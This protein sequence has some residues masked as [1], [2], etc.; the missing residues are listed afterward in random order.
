MRV[1]S[2]LFALL[3]AGPMVG[4]RPADDGDGAPPTQTASATDAGGAGSTPATALGPTPAGNGPRVV[5][6]GTSLTAGYGLPSPDES[7]VA[8]LQEMAD[9]AGVPARLVNAGVS[10][11]TSAG[12]LRRIG[13]VVRDTVDVLVLELGANDGLRG[14]DTEALATNL[15]AIVDSTRAHWPAAE[16]V[17]VGMRA[18]PN[19]GAAYT[20]AFDAVF[21][22][23]ARQKSATLVPFLLDGVAGVRELNQDDGIHPTVEG[24]RRLARNVWP[25]LLPALRRS[26][27]RHK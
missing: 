23:V 11:E 7:Y 1:H 19:L 3:L 15:G 21:P 8:R 26:E 14:Q 16:I 6:I 27:A 9:S 24:H 13:W 18:P 2:L 25:I 5:V 20:S 17:L 22:R 4:C 10:G 12:G